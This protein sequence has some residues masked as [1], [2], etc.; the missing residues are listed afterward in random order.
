VVPIN[1]QGSNTSKEQKYVTVLYLT[2]AGYAQKYKNDN[3]QLENWEDLY[4]TRPLHESEEIR[5]NKRY[6]LPKY[7]KK[8][9]WVVGPHNV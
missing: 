3:P 8:Q 6:K 1:R 7:E 5:Y 2:K 9:M 4:G